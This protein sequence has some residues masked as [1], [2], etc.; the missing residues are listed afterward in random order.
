MRHDRDLSGSSPRLHH[1]PLVVLTHRD[2]VIDLLQNPLLDA[3][4]VPDIVSKF[5]QTVPLDV[6]LN[7]G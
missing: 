2:D 7:D 5:G 3:L 1:A 4:D 6:V